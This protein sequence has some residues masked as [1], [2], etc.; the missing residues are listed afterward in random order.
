MATDGIWEG[1][2]SATEAQIEERVNGWIYVN[3]NKKLFK[4]HLR[5]DR[6]V[7]EGCWTFLLGFEVGRKAGDGK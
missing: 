7:N 6:Q 1:A 5:F 2:G 4:T 3:L